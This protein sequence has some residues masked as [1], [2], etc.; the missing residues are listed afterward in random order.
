[1]TRSEAIW[2]LW[3]NAV[4]AGA[5]RDAVVSNRLS[6]AYLVAGP[7]NV[8]KTTLAHALAKSLLCLAVVTPG[9]ACGVC[10]SCRKID[11]GV[12]PDV[13]T[14]N[15]A[16]QAAAASGKQGSKNTTLTIETI[17]SMTATAALR[18][19]EGVWRVAIVDDA[20]LLQGTAQEAMLKTL[21]EPPSF[22]IMLLLTD[23]LDVLLPTIRSRA[24]LLE[25][26]PVPPGEIEG[27]LSARGIPAERALELAALANGA[28]G[29][30]IRAANESALLTE[31]VAAIDRALTW[32][33]ADGHQRVVTAIRL[34]DNFA[35]D[36]G[37]VFA[38]LSMLIGV[39]RDAMLIGAGQE[40][41]VH[42]KLRLTQLQSLA[43]RWS[44][45]GVHGALCSVRT[46]VLDLEAN[47]RPR[48]AIEHMV[49]QWPTS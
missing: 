48:L 18:P 47:V 13:Q 3:G 7:P 37:R 6:H 39:W 10:L 9:E 22:T 46:C 20:E 30:A 24:Q 36:R 12:H 45:A 34:G 32:A 35:K 21:E 14:W 23:D 43:D 42:F 17:R 19:M 28:P 15:L 41:H 26:R 38:D 4:A 2:G 5:L 11:R 8:G 33:S 25:M 40:R 29:W 44:L 16:S 27:G 31:R 1:M 49:Q